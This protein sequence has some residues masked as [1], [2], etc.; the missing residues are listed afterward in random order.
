M[1]LVAWSQR[2]DPTSFYPVMNG[3]QYVCEACPCG[4]TSLYAH[5][6]AVVAE[7]PHC[8]L[9]LRDGKLD[10]VHSLGARH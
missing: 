10:E 1:S 3:T 7:C 2:S 5:N 9:I 8:V 6:E 4:E